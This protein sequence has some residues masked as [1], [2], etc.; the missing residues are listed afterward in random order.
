MTSFLVSQLSKSFIFVFFKKISSYGITH[1]FILT[2][3]NGNSMIIF[4]C[5]FLFSLS[6]LTVSVV[7]RAFMLQNL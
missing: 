5:I 6:V 3:L 4:I 2:H 7:L 1:I